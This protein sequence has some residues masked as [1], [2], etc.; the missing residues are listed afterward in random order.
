MAAELRSKYRSIVEEMFNRWTALR[1]AVEHGM[2]VE[3][4]G[5]QAAIEILDYMT[6]YCLNMKKLESDDVQEALDQIMDQEYDTICDDNSTRELSLYLVKYLTMLRD[7]KDQEIINEINQLPAC[8][9][10]INP[11]AKINY[12]TA[13]ES[14]SSDGEDMETEVVPST[15]GSTTAVQIEPLE[16]VDPGWTVVKTKRKNK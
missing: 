2:H 12:V 5:L 13:P 11:K 16:E 1:L 3:N 7:G 14:D 10:W 6:D 9:K 8:E 15:S 4:N